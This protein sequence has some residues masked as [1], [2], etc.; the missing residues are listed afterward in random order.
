MPSD[1]AAKRSQPRR[2][3]YRVIE[4]RGS[5]S[6]SGSTRRGQLISDCVEEIIA[7]CDLERARRRPEIDSCDAHVVSPQVQ[8][9]RSRAPGTDD[10]AL[11]TAALRP[12]PRCRASFKL[13][14]TGV[15]GANA[16]VRRKFG[17]R[18][19]PRFGWRA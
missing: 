10:D 5:T 13:S 19:R 17:L 9:V 4:T 14:T 2:R 1:T 8:T 16:A 7:R 3:R 18:S 12:P 11:A 6:H 15:T